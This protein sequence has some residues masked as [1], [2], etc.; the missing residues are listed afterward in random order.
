MDLQLPRQADFSASIFRRGQK[1][2]LFDELQE[3][4]ASL[5]SELKSKLENLAS[6]WAAERVGKELSAAIWRPDLE[7]AEVVLQRGKAVAHLG[8]QQRSKLYLHIE[9]AVCV[10]FVVCVFW[11]GGRDVLRGVFVGYGLCRRLFDPAGAWP[12][13]ARKDGKIRPPHPAPSP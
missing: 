11:V 6:L 10:L 7:L 8:C 13:V 4:A 9:E 3:D 12:R 1:K 5:E 2:E